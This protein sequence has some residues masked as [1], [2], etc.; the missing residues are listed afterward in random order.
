MQISAEVELDHTSPPGA[1]CD[2]LLCS[3]QSL[4]K[5]TESQWLTLG[6]SDLFISSSTKHTDAVIPCCHSTEEQ[7]QCL[8]T[9]NKY[10]FQ[11]SPPPPHIMCDFR[12]SRGRSGILK[13]K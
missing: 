2:V 1:L 3:D 8:L 9:H 6:H 5:M 12:G 13:P 7:V 4:S 11:D 10:Q